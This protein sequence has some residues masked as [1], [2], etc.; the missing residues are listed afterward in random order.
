ME[1]KECWRLV[2]FRG[3][4][5]GM[6]VDELIEGTGSLHGHVTSVEEVAF[7]SRQRPILLPDRLLTRPGGQ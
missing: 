5:E 7:I 4:V 3:H 2:R 6:S 1:W